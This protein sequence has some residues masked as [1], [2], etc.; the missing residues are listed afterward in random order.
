M[1]IKPLADRVLVKPAP[2]EEK[3]IGGIIIPD[4]AQEK[5]SRG[6]VVAVG[7]ATACSMANMPARKWKSTAR[8]CSSCAR[9]TSLPWWNKPHRAIF[10][11]WR[12]NSSYI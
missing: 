12:I 3:T 10:A 8:S 2:A 7:P 9:A 1:T 11:P 6:T 4:T 5:P